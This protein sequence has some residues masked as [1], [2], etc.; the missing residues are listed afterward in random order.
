MP[1][2]INLKTDLTKLKANAQ[3]FNKSITAES[4]DLLDLRTDMTMLKF[5]NDQP[6]Y[7]SSGLPYIQTSVPPVPN[8][9][10]AKGPGFPVFTPGTTGNLDYPIRGGQIAFQIGQQ[11]YT[12]SSQIDGVRI[13]KF[14]KDPKRGT[15]F[16]QKQIGLQLT[17]PKIETGDALFGTGQAA[18]L[19][20]ILENTRIY[21]RGI[22]TLAQVEVAGT[23]AHVV[24]HGTTP[25]A[26]FQKNYYAI[27][28]EQNVLG[29]ADGTSINR[30]ATLYAMK[31]TPVFG[32]NFVNPVEVDVDINL[33]NKLGIS[34]NRNLMFQ[35][36]G[37]PGSSY[38]LGSTTIGRYVDTSGLFEQNVKYISNDP[39]VDYINKIKQYN[40]DA[41]LAVGTSINRLLELRNSKILN[42][43]SSGGFKIFNIA[44][45]EDLLL[46]YVNG[47]GTA[48][49]D[50]SR[51]KTKTDIKR[52]T[53]TTKVGSSRSMNYRTLS[54]QKI[55][56]SIYATATQGLV[57]SKNRDIQD[58]RKDLPQA[59]SMNGFWTDKQSLDYRF[60]IKN[61]HV[62]KLNALFPFLFE[63]SQNPWNVPL[64][65]NKS[66]DD[67]IKFV[68]EAIN[69]DD[70]SL[71]TAIFFRAFL[72]NITDNNSATWNSFKYQGRGENFYTYQGF[73]RSIS[74]S[75]RVYASSEE[76]MRPMYNR[77]NNLIS[78]VY[79]DYTKDQGIMRGPMMRLTI[80][81]YI[82]RMPG[83]LESV[84]LTVDPNNGWEIKQDYQLP[85]V[86]DVQ[87]SFKPV[88]ETLPR[89]ANS[90]YTPYVPS[91][92]A[93]SKNPIIEE[94]LK[95]VPE[96]AVVKDQATQ[97]LQEEVKVPKDFKINTEF[98]NIPFR[99]TLDREEPIN[100]DPT[101]F[102]PRLGNF[103]R[104][105]TTNN[106]LPTFSP[107]F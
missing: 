77:L 53:N 70:T 89:R 94:T 82:R 59:K 4:I 33:V 74:F 17:N 75:F 2:L 40:F 91:F 62:D 19:S 23:G 104:P 79:P 57:N 107:R 41:V 81:D 97:K 50:G 48:F 27:V 55:N 16:V 9:L 84:N 63:N 98:P 101:V 34:S 78:Q 51:D 72:G 44:S 60:Y 25:F 86:V 24:R 29:N 103:T 76:E 1:A 61:T 45:S 11:T 85:H 10:N 12:L 65:D 96:N 71:S 35:Y 52:P 38:G 88:L 36:L 8:L 5:G 80:G 20:G 6:G 73:D 3:A 105:T 39:P 49:G 69:N 43:Q 30:L 42:I 31:M 7:G 100:T 28:N 32:G 83:F 21:N 102:A 46:S 90:L 64:D 22:N 37:G 54:E 14:L 66:S 95:M 47:P 92:I 106:T 18:P 15:L 26:A 68:F 93:N 87:V 99:P 58:F 13:A 67:I 56:E